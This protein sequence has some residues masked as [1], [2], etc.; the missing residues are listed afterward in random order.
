MR[1]DNILASQWRCVM[2]SVGTQENTTQTQEPCADQHISDFGAVTPVR[3]GIVGASGYT[4]V[5]LALLVANHPHLELVAVSSTSQASTSLGSLYPRIQGTPADLTLISTQEMYSLDLDVVFLAVPHTT[6]AEI[7]AHFLELNTKVIDLAADFRLE[8]IAIFNGFYSTSHPLPHLV[9][10]A[11]YGLPEINRTQIA[12]TK[13]VANPGCYPTATL[14]AALPIVKMKQF[15]ASSIVVSATS[16][17]SGMGRSSKDAASFCVADEAFGAYKPLVHQH[18][19]E[20]AQELTRAAGRTISVAFVPHVGPFKR[21]I[22]TD[23]FVTFYNPQDA[24]PAKLKALYTD[25]YQNEPFVQI[26]DLGQM[27][28]VSQ[29]T[30]TNNAVIGISGDIHSGVAVISCAIDNLSKG[31]ASQ[32]VQNLNIMFGLDE[33]AGLITMGSVI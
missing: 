25:A 11:V 4:G 17:V 26:L 8:D 2:T 22:L 32:A 9:A 27:P 18:A 33:T 13:L 3:V 31:A 20:I 1:F 29:V 15:S 30:A 21:G 7:A 24:D 14:L 19:P 10:Q 23:V 16:G 6:S 5:E 12:T 28:N